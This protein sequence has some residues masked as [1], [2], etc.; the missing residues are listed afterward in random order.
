LNAYDSKALQSCCKKRD[1]C[2][3][4]FRYDFSRLR[5]PELFQPP[6]TNRPLIGSIEVME[7]K[8]QR[9][10]LRTL[11]C[12]MFG[13]VFIYAG[14]LKASDP[15]TFLDDVRSFQIL[16]DPYA[17][18]LALALPWLEIFSGLAVITGLL[19]HGGLLTLNALLLVFLA[20]ILLS[21][22]RGLDLSCGC[23]GGDTSASNYPTLILRD[24]ALLALGFACWKLAPTSHRP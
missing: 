1:N 8:P 3:H 18:W 14:A 2:Q 20:A 17:A 10:L 13:A 12:L 19:R 9:R 7:P 21:W 24:L 23:F 4:T 5:S 15:M 11:L 6:E 22:A 16:P